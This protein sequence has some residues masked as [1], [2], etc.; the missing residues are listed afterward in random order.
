MGRRLE[1]CEKGL[2][3]ENFRVHGAG[4][5][6][7]G[8][9]FQFGFAPDLGQDGFCSTW[10]IF[11]FGLVPKMFHVEHSPLSIPPRARV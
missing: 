6:I 11:H 5:G 9:L 4:L 8:W 10:N 1:G 7:S 3:V 2:V